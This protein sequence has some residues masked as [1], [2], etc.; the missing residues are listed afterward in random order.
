MSFRERLLLRRKGGGP[1]SSAAE[2]DP[3]YHKSKLRESL[4]LWDERG[5]RSRVMWHLFYLIEINQTDS[6]FEEVVSVPPLN[7]MIKFTTFG[8]CLEIR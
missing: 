1:R 7:V 4:K 2:L 8:L 3:D 6:L 5:I